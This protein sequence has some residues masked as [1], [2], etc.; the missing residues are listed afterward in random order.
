M[1]VVNPTQE[2]LLNRGVALPQNVTGGAL[3][4][5]IEPESPAALA[6]ILPGDVLLQIHESSIKSVDEM[7]KT[8]ENQ[9]VVLISFWRGENRYLAAVANPVEPG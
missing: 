9:R 8:V 7:I 3:V 1:S 4:T 2:L 6:G 5:A